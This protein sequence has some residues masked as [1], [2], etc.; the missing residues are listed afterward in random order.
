MSLITYKLNIM[1]Y[2]SILISLTI[3]QDEIREMII[4]FILDK[5]KN[6]VYACSTDKNSNII[7]EGYHKLQGLDNNQSHHFWKQWLNNNGIFV[8]Y[9]YDSIDNDNDPTSTFYNI[10]QYMFNF[11]QT[12]L[13]K[14]K[15][16]I[17][18]SYQYQINR[19][20][21][22][23]DENNIQETFFKPVSIQIT[24]EQFNTLN[25]RIMGKNIKKIFN[26]NQTLCVICQE[27]IRSRQ[28]CT[29]LI[30]N[31]LYHKICAREWFTQK[32]ILPSCPSCRIDIR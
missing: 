28:H 26:I 9:Y 22:D 21:Q 25:N 29:I 2:S 23:V 14:I 20:S 27:E 15:P 10:L 24:K 5:Q 7:L 17:H 11:N 4:K 16:L 19:V 30:C 18:E 13:I 8:K 1:T 3:N 12:N 32:C 6:L 31:H